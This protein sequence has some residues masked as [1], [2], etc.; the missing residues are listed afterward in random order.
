MDH[1]VIGRVQATAFL[2]GVGEDG[3]AAVVL[4]ADHLARV[5]AKG[6]LPA[7]EVEGVA[8]AVPG[9]RAEAAADMAV[10]LQPAQLLV[11]GDV[12][13]EQEAADS[14]PGRPFGPERAVMEPH[15]RRIPEL[16][17]KARIEH[18]H[19]RVGIADRQ[20]TRRV[21]AGHGRWGQD[22][23]HGEGRTQTQGTPPIEHDALPGGRPG[24][25]DETLQL[26]T[27]HDR[28]P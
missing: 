10:L 24:K 16:G 13:P 8:V 11:I 7:L 5:V 18:H 9:R 23:A 4:V 15:D 3:D 28:S 26:H 17:A 2:V 27:W 21:V 1:A 20:G 6:D 19:I 12:R 25:V 22:A 14:A